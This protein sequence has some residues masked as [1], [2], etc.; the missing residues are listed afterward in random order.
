MSANLVVASGKGGTGKTTVATNL[1][2]VAT[3]AGHKVHLC[4]CDV[5]EPNAHLFVSPEIVHR[6]DV[7]VSLPVVNANLCEH[8]GTCAEICEFNAIAAMPQRTIVFED[9][10]HA[11]GGC[12]LVCP[13]E[14]ITDTAKRVGVLETGT[15]HGFR[16]SHGRLDVGQVRVPPVIEAVLDLQQS[17]EFVIRDA[18]PGVTC[19]TVAALRGADY[20]MLVTEPTPFGLHDLMAAVD[21]VRAMDLPCGVVVNRDGVGDDRVTRFCADEGIALLPGIPFRLDV[22]QAVSRGELIVETV[23]EIRDAFVRL[24]DAVTAR[25]RKVQEVTT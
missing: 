8:C 9:L 23:P 17:D 1:A 13:C 22:A 3:A 21:L 12:R 16:F 2:V 11:C 15:A 25:L 19:P 5:E 20:A 6:Q 14:A 4:D 24:L 7:T 10:C 18:P